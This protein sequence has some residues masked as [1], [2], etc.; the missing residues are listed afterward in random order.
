MGNYFIGSRIYSWKL[1][2]VHVFWWFRSIICIVWKNFALLLF[3]AVAKLLTAQDNYIF[4][5][6]LTLNIFWRLDPNIYKR[7][8][9]CGCGWFD[10]F[11]PFEVQ[12]KYFWIIGKRR[13]KV[14]SFQ[15]LLLMQLYL[16]HQTKL[17]CF[18]ILK[19]L[20]LIHILTFAAT[21]TYIK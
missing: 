18:K 8:R 11:L 20:T 10:S 6:R 3:F 13:R 21:R 19:N 2:H 4:P 5:Q 9:G 15:L 16:N 12:Q 7:G 1:S 14:L 17:R